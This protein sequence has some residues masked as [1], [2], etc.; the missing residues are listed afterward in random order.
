MRV[1]ADVA[2]AARSGA[3]SV[4]HRSVLVIAMS[5]R[6][7]TGRRLRAAVSDERVVR[8]AVSDCH[9]GADAAEMVGLSLPSSAITRLD[10]MRNN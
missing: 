9:H 1:I 5:A 8:R 6:T 3:V 4:D 2:W 10:K 7:E